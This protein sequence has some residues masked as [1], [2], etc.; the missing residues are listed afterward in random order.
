MITTYNHSPPNVCHTTSS[1]KSHFTISHGP[2]EV[3]ESDDVS[4]EVRDVGVVDRT[5]D[6]VR[7]KVDDLIVPVEDLE[8]GLLPLTDLRK[9]DNGNGSRRIISFGLQMRPYN[10]VDFRP[11]DGV[12]DLK[13]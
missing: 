13:L 4:I 11:E 1:F 7:E 2:E 10:F 3:L 5:G 9:K 12:L 8:D 6:V